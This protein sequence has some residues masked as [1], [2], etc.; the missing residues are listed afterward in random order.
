MHERDEQRGSGS[1]P[2]RSCLRKARGLP[3]LVGLGVGAVPLLVGCAAD[4]DDEVEL[5]EE[6]YE[7]V[8]EADIEDV[9]QSEQEARSALP[10]CV[11]RAYTFRR[12]SRRDGWGRPRA[13]RAGTRARPSRARTGRGFSARIR[14]ART[15][16]GHDGRRSAAA[17]HRYLPVRAQEVRGGPNNDTNWAAHDPLNP[18]VACASLELAN[19]WKPRSPTP[20][21][22]STAPSERG[23]AAALEGGA[24]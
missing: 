21:I 22:S 2:W 18:A 20:T 4:M 10:S 8:L 5:G 3:L 9:A 24:P 15:A 14:M 23:A 1:G 16:S 12:E 7:D 17:H 6:G 13:T 19:K 11:T